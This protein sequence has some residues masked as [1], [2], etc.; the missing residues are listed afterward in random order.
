MFHIYLIYLLS[1]PG[2]SS[3]PIMVSV[4]FSPTQNLNHMVGILS[5]NF[6]SVNSRFIFMEFL[7]RI[8]TTTYIYKNIIKI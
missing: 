6:L 8:N 1:S 5:F 2:V 3:N 7:C 4:L